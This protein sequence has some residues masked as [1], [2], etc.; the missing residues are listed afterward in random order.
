MNLPMLMF[1]SLDAWN[2]LLWPQI[3]YAHV[4][5]VV[6]VVSPPLLVQILRLFFFHYSNFHLLYVFDLNHLPMCIMREKQQH[7]IVILIDISIFVDLI[8][9]QASFACICLLIMTMAFVFSMYTFLN[10]RYMF[11]RL[12]AGVHFIS[13]WSEIECIWWMKLSPHS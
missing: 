13:G 4:V 7:H 2:E 11:K 9:T 6:V 8:R 10:P 3:E 12:A 5:F 1:Q